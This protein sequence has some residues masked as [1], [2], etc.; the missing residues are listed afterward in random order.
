MTDH[1]PDDDDEGP[2][3][4]LDAHGDPVRQGALMIERQSYERV[5][6]GLRIAAEACM[7]LAKWETTA[8]GVDNRKG[9]ARKLDQCRRACIQRAGLDDVVRAS[10]TAEVRGVPLAWRPARDRLLQGLVQA[11]G[12]ARQLATCHRMD[13]MWSNVAREL[14][15]LE[16][17]VRMP[18]R[19]AGF[20]PLLGPAGYVRH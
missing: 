11:M 18:K 15:R 9:L 6:D 10:P 13:L 16:R 2:G 3:I 7:H 8:E 5:I 17:N 19:V 4:Q 12:G 1:P 20:N 14:E